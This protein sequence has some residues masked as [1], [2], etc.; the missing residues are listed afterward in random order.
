MDR[1]PQSFA[2]RLIDPALFGTNNDYFPHIDAILGPRESR[3]FGS[4]FQRVRYGAAVAASERGPSLA[5]GSVCV[6]YPVNWSVKAAPRRLRPHLSTIDAVY[7]GTALSEWAL[8]F[9]FAA[10]LRHPTPLITH[11]ELKSGAAPDENLEA[12]PFTLRSIGTAPNKD[13]ASPYG[14]N[15]SLQLRIGAMQLEVE[16]AHNA[17]FEYGNTTRQPDPL[18]SQGPQ[19]Q[20]CRLATEGAHQIDLQHV[21]L[22]RAGLRACAE[23]RF[24]QAAPGYRLLSYVEFALASAQLAQAIIYRTDR[25]QRAH[26]NTL[27]MRDFRIAA[28]AHC[29]VSEPQLIELR[30][31]NHKRQ[32]IGG[33]AWSV[34]RFSCRLGPLGATFTFAHRLE[35]VQAAADATE[36]N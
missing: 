2:S 32:T 24:G 23:I 15:T 29:G 13:R 4:G 12:L 9:A 18:A 26:S 17:V 36:R 8:H 6:R 10:P 16:I 20:A 30:T 27:W 19:A 33:D 28:A 5:D 22:D 34:Y 3:Y 14:L 21:L 31:L 1:G 25:I 35:G 11:C 7:L